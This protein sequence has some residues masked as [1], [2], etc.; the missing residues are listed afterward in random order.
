METLDK[1]K[2]E[3]AKII[4]Q[5]PLLSRKEEMSLAK[6]INKY[7]NGKKRQKAREKLYFSNL[8][9]VYKRANSFINKYYAHVPHIRT[10][11]LQLEDLI[12]AGIEGLGMA[13]D[14][15]RPEEFK[16]KFSTMAIHWI[17]LKIGTTIA[18]IHS[19]LY[20]PRYIRN[21][22]KKLKD[23]LCD[24]RKMTDEEIMKALKISPYVFRNVQASAKSVTFSLNDNCYTKAPLTNS[25]LHSTLQDVIEDTKTKSPDISCVEKDRKVMVRKCLNK[26]DP[27]SREILCCRYMNAE[28]EGLDKIG[29]RHGLSGERIRQISDMALEKA[30]RYFKGVS[31]F[32]V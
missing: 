15:F 22:N 12:A 2:Q 30:K 24:N 28:K 27:L 4:E 10:C 8:R 13:I 18:D 3:Y 20:I 9:L 26:L 31:F 11:M 1:C 14:R 17:D 19:D 23:L 5:Y 6:I 21:K 16:T 29:K 32:E 25:M 7:K